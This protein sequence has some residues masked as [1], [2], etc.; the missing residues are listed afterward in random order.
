MSIA[1]Q[2]RKR[3]ERMGRGALDVVFDYAKRLPWVRERIAAEY[4]KVVAELRASAR[5]Y[6]DI[7]PTWRT[8]PER[9]RDREEILAE[10]T[11][12]RDAE[13]ERWHDGYVS[14]CVYHGGEEHVALLDRATAMF[15]QANP[16][17]ADIWPSVVKF[18]AEIVAMAGAMLGGEHVARHGGGEGEPCGVVTSGGTESILLAM[19]TYRDW[20]RAERGI[21]SP[22]IVLP[23]TAH[24]A[25]DKAAQYFGIEP[26]RVDVGPD[27]RADVA[28]TKRALGRNSIC[29]VGSAPAFPHGQID[30]IAEL[31]ELAR[32]RGIGFHTD[33][34]LGGF[35][36]PFAREIGHPVPD[37][38]FRLPGVTSI[39]AD[40]HKYGYAAKGTSVL[41]WRSKALRRHQFFAATEWPGG[42]YCSPT[43]AGSR[44]GALSAACWAAMMSMG[45]E[46]YRDATRRILDTASKIKRGIAGIRGLRVLGEPLWVIAFAADDVDIYR[47]LDAMTHRE[48]NLNG[49]HKPPC[50]HIAVTLRHAE[51]GVAERFLADLR[52]SVEYVRA[53]PEQSGGMAP[54]YGMAG[55]LPVR[56]VVDD[57]LRAY[58]EVLYET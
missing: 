48:W 15:S 27:L 42:M 24:V 33:A 6:K 19:K 45:G 53:H 30:P 41:L 32:D 25:F 20:A 1:K 31:S 23:T 22:Q 8:L 57:L 4:D 9:G 3:L 11:S 50:V 13:V 21:T 12:L 17:H 51:P 10:M 2:T 39:S 46:G 58:L 26:V 40:T 14:G 5:P 49:L 47:V 56:G 16:L 44:P 54:V 7:A 28:A 35:V 52:E 34:C 43:L 38:D 36:L 37:F 18:E 29:V 55:T